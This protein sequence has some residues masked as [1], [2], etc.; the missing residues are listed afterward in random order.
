MSKS[1]SNKKPSN[2]SLAERWNKEKADGFTV[3]RKTTVKKST[4]KNK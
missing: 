1:S 4:K 3:I 2:P